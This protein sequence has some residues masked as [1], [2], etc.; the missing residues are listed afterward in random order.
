MDVCINLDTQAVIAVCV[1]V[2][3]LAVALRI[4]W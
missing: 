2:V 1:S 3:L 4:R